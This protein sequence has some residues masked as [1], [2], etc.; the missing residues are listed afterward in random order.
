MPLLKTFMTQAHATGLLV[1]D[2]LARSL[3]IPP[4]EMA[5]RHR[6]SDLA[7]DHV[8]LTWGPADRTGRADED[9]AE[10][11]R[12]ITTFAHCDFGSVTLLFNWLGGL[13]IADRASGD[14][15]WVRPLPGHAIVNLGDAMVVFSGGRLASGKHRVVQA[16]GAQARCER[17]SCVYFVRPSN[18]TFMEDLVGGA[19]AGGQAVRLDAKDQNAVFDTSRRWR[20]GDWIDKRARDMGNRFVVEGKEGQ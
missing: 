12:R 3:G 6:P 2:A 17:L 7:G 16:P 14:W 15:R 13:Q 19:D 4:D 9:G 1:L 20:A 10:K 8:R 11:D 5:K 18:E